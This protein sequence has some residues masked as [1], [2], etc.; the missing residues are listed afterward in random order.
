MAARRTAA[1]KPPE[2]TKAAD[3]ATESVEE[4][5]VEAPVEEEAAAE[6]DQAEEADVPAST[7]RG[8]SRPLRFVTPQGVPLNIQSKGEPARQ[9]QSGLGRPLRF[10][11]K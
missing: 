1:P 4:E 5:S 3:E 9:V 11:G 6:V 10:G 8:A 7:A 2:D